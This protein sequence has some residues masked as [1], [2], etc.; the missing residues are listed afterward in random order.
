MYKDFAPS[1]ARRW[2]HKVVRRDV[3]T[4]MEET[5]AGGSAGTRDS[6]NP[7]TRALAADPAALY[8]MV[9]IE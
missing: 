7:N 5:R 4:W 6:A 2:K 1:N 9:E 8:S 3:A